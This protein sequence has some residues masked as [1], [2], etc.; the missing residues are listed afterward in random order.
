MTS[1][2]ERWQKYE[3]EWLRKYANAR[4]YE[5]I[6]KAEDGEEHFIGQIADLMVEAGGRDG[7]ITREQA[8]QYLL[9]SSQGQSLVARLAPIPQG[10]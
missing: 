9:H 6:F 5:G 2:R 7:P 3:R 1:R 4:R 10:D 8:L